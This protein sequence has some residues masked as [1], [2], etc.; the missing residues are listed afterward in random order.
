MLAWV[1]LCF[2]G[3]AALLCAI[4]IFGLTSFSVTQRTQEIGVRVALGATRGSIQ[5]LVMK[6]VSFLAATGCAVGL[7]VFLFA[8]RVLSTTLFELSPSDPASLA[9][10]AAILGGAALLAGFLPAHRAT[11]VDPASTLR[12]E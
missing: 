6:E 7:V 8:G 10:G 2:A 1:S 9:L 11:R 4:G 5:W 3:L 12:Q